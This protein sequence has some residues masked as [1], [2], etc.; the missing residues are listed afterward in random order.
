MFEE[1]PTRLFVVSIGTGVV[2]VNAKLPIDV[3]ELNPLVFTYQYLFVISPC[4]FDVLGPP[5]G[6]DSCASTSKSSVE[7]PETVA[8]LNLIGSYKSLPTGKVI[9][10]VVPVFTT[11][12]NVPL[13]YDEPDPPVMLEVALILTKPL[14]HT[15]LPF[16]RI[17][18]DTVTEE[19]TAT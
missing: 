10:E 19:E 5:A 6:I 18:F 3:I 4:K 16:V 11:R 17:R 1:K 2:G 13:T 12:I 15:K 14:L 7:K 8:L 9:D